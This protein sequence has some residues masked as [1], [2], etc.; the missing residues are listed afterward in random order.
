MLCKKRKE[1]DLQISQETTCARVSFLIKLQTQA[2]NFIEKETL[3]PLFSCE[4]RK[5]LRA[6]SY[7]T[8]PYDC[9]C[10]KEW[11]APKVVTGGVLKTFAK[12]TGKH[13][14]KSLFLIKH[15]CF[16]MNFSKFSETPFL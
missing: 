5:F 12:F 14:S 16:P 10:F 1:K 6:L 15:R 3:A 7:R 13:L 9:F 8:S 4:F 11:K 2:F